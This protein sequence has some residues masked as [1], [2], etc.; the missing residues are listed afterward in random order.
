MGFPGGPKIYE[1]A[2]KGKEF[3]ELPYVVK[4][5][6][7]SVGGILTNVKQKYDSKKFEL[8]DLAYSIQETVFAMLIAVAERAMAHC[9]IEELLLGGGV[10]CNKRL[11]EMAKIM[12]KERGAKLY[13]PQNNVLV[14]NGL[15]IAWQGLL[16]KDGV[17]KI[18]DIDIKPGWRT[19]QVDVDWR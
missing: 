3:I 18:D 10:C 4:G 9:E 15:M 2:L 5:M 17:R 8:E 19:D 1:L 12:C 11:Q 6:D 14:D 7:I 16:E 13:V